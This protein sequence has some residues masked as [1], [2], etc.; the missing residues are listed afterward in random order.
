MRRQI[1]QHISEVAQEEWNACATKEKGLNPFCSHGFL[2]ALEESGCVNAESG[3]LPQHILLR[4]QDTLVGAIPL[5]LKN[6]SQGEYVFDHGWANAYQQ[7]GGSYYPKLQ[8]SIPFSPVSGPRLLSN[9]QEFKSELL[10]TAIRHAETCGVSS[11]HF[12]FVEDDDLNTMTAHGLLHRQD[13]QY[14]WQNNN[15]ISFDEFLASLSS[16]KRKNILKERRTA[17]SN[18]DLKIELVQSHD[19]KEHHW[20][21]Y[22]EFYLD[23]SDRKWGRPYLNR[24]FFSLLSEYIPENLL[25][26]LAKRGDKY[27]AGALNLIGEDCLY[28]RY[29]GATEYHKYLHFELCYY[30]A[31]DFAIQN[32]LRRVEAGAQGEHK[33]ARGYI[34][35]ATNSMHWIS[36]HSFKDAVQKY[37]TQERDA[38]G[39]DIDILKGFTP[40]RRCE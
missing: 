10:E 4:E 38:I 15:Y 39:R 12:T 27:I 18:A 30:Q 36:N 26:I 31:I 5:Y 25:L 3:W 11:M 40:F 19:I 20:D 24:I 34:P 37:L 17:L 8:C 2:R 14:H 33:I 7:A 23:T 32:K 13:I 28:G 1:I 35:T 29:W 16:R 22:F 9:S 21:H 6:H